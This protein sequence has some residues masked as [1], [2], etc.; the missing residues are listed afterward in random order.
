MA[1]PVAA[2]ARSRSRGGWVAGGVALLVVLAG[3]G[4][5]WW[6]ANTAAPLD[7]SLTAPAPAVALA[8][9]TVQN[10][11]ALASAS[12]QGR[13]YRA[14]V[15]YADEV[16]AMQ[17][18]HAEATRIRTEAGA[19]LA[20]F[21]EAV[22]D[23]RNRIAASDV[24][25]AASALET[26]RTIDPSAPVVVE[27]SSRLSDLARRTSAGTRAGERAA[28]PP[29]QPAPRREAAA[30]KPAP[31]EPEA[32]APPPVRAEPE[33][34][35]VRTPAPAPTPVPQAPVPAAPAPTPP[36]AAPAVTTPPAPVVTPA[37]APATPPR[38]ETPAPSAPA[39]T[40]DAAIRRLAA[41]YARAI[42]NKDI[43]LFRSIKPN[44]SGEEERR[45]Q[46]GFRA[47]TS[48]RVN[49]S[50][51][52]ID[53]RGDEATVV[54]RR[55]DT[56]QAGGRQHTAE[57]RQTLGVAQANGQWVIVDIR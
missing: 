1:P 15:A 6:R 34:P 14:A 53:R 17:A 20:R 31:V 38:T 24:A 32:P 16:L 55:R 49:L 39:E 57:S 26:A 43:A 30:A 2:P 11:L 27:L 36:P 35:E 22:A 37:P 46:E 18:G 50:V 12:L 10:R 40:A 56:I 21:D 44:L 9:A 3:G 28:A 13:N 47:V 8:E 7:T 41:T 19:M 4:Y 42:E 54:V 52:S 5:A 23:A 33:K 29:A 51:V 25:G 48:Q 45:L